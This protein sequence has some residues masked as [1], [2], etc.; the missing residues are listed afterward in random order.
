[1]SKIIVV[2]Y[3]PDWPAVFERLRPS[4]WP[5]VGD[6]ASS[7]EHVGSTSVV[8]L[9]AKPIIDLVIVV[10][11][12]SDM[13]RA[14]KRLAD[15]GYEHR[16]DLGVPGREAFEA[17]SRSPAHHLYACVEGNLGLRNQLTVRDRLRQAPELAR[18][19]GKL[20]KQLAARFPDDIDAYIAGK[21]DF[22]LDI[23]AEAGFTQTER[24]A[25]EAVNRKP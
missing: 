18:A 16:G 13:T 19:Y 6:V 17:S 8:G 3:D 2:N 9:A 20:K 1:M 10:P 4:I 15:I 24:D 21:S 25:I 14:I 12:A 22:I 7:I 11:T 5:A 23:L